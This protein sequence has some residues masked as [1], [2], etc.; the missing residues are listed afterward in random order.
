MYKDFDEDEGPICPLLPRGA[1]DDM[2]A[3]PGL[4]QLA[5]ATPGAV[6]D[7]RDNIPDEAPVCP[8]MDFE[9]HVYDVD[10]NPREMGLVH[11]VKDVAGTVE[12]GASVTGYDSMD[13]DQTVLG[14]LHPSISEPTPDLQVEVEPEEHDTRLEC[15]P[16]E[17]T[18]GEDQTTF[19]SSKGDEILKALPKPKPKILDDDGCKSTRHL[20]RRAENHSCSQKGTT[21]RSPRYGQ[22]LAVKVQ[23][24]TRR[25]VHRESPKPSSQW[26]CRS[27]HLKTLEQARVA[28]T[29]R[30]N[31]HS[32]H[33]SG[34]VAGLHIRKPVR[35]ENRLRPRWECGVE[36]C[37][38]VFRGDAASRHHTLTHFNL[39][40]ICFGCNHSFGMEVASFMGHIEEAHRKDTKG[41]CV[42]K[43]PWVEKFFQSSAKVIVRARTHV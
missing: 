9:E 27:S 21:L 35:I 12:G 28:V 37:W 3:T 30:Q 6:P 7:T 39:H 22:D 13:I 43:N 25:V 32:L 19:K 4:I 16:L 8:A 26:S 5:A 17:L 42:L 24:S 1:L 40:I 11:S 18:T 41:A 10:R 31:N 38:R 29:G 23:R 14:T 2:W 33:T 34:G 15:V 20:P 36:G